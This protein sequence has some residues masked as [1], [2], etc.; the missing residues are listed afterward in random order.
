VICQARDVF[1]VWC[2]KILSPSNPVE[3][4][5]NQRAFYEEYGVEEDYVYNPGHQPA[6]DLRA[7]R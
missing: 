1:G 6:A 3:E 2:L 5:D 7:P 4:V